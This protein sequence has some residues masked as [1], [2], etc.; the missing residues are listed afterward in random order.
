VHDR[1]IDGTTHTF[2]NAG[3]L[4]M[5]AM[6]WWDHETGSIWSQPWGRAIR[7]DLKGIELFLLPS[8]LTTWGSWKEEHPNTLVMVNDLELLGS[9]RVRFDSDFVIGLLLDGKAKA[10]QFEDVVEGVVVNDSFAGFSVLVWAEGDRFHA[11]LRTVNDM[12]LTFRW[13]QGRLLDNETNSWW[14]VALGLAVDGELKGEALQPVPSSTAF[15]WAWLDF[16]PDSEM[17]TP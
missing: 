10:Y 1:R 16:Y 2:G 7:G 14:N 15:D 13:E 9:N 17:Y 3:A 11:Y 12:E 5:R 8:E 4:F 6:T